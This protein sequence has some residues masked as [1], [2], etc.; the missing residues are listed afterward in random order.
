M[1]DRAEPRHAHRGKP[2]DECTREELLEACNLVCDQLE[3][4]QELA[5]T[6]R[7]VAEIAN[8]PR[9]LR[10]RRGEVDGD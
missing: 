1:S 4:V 3:E 9:M 6:W 10:E 2:L 5:A 7:R 8:I